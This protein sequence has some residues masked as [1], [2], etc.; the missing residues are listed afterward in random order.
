MTFCAIY[1]VFHVQRNNAYLNT[2]LDVVQK[3]AEYG[4]IKKK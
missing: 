4:E 1:E 2:R 3:H